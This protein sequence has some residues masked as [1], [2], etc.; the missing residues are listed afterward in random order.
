MSD[1]PEETGPVSTISVREYRTERK[2]A[3]GTQK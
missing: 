2:G 1:D 3:S